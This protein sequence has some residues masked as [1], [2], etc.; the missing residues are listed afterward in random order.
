M[1]PFI[2][3]FSYRIASYGLC[4]LLGCM[5]VLLWTMHRAKK[6]NIRWEDVLVVGVTAVGT[7]IVCAKLLYIAVSYS[8][9][10]IGAMLA[11]GNF[12]FLAEDGLVFY[13]GLIGGIFGAFLG[14]KLAGV[15][16]AEL[17]PY[18]AP[19]LP[20]G[21]AIGRVGCALAGCCYGFV[22]DGFG[23]V[24]YPNI[25]FDFPAHTGYFPVQLA[26]A[27]FDVC[28][29]VYLLHFAKKER[30]KYDIL[31]RYLFLYAILR[32]GTE[33]LRGDVVRGLYFSLSTSQWISI[34][35]LAVCGVRF[36]MKRKK[37]A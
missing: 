6:K 25:V 37:N 35:L 28:I 2:Q 10:E 11:S 23:A 5:T 16:V 30:G 13:G 19:L 29:M 4:I 18:A 33:F 20:L 7:A 24:Y 34:G 15:R 27:F 32:F 36:F 3:I 31:F 8:M 14:A 26:E 17:E 9:A 22:Y 1:Y 21:H 12:S